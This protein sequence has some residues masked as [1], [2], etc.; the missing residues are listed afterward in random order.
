MLIG[1]GHQVYVPTLP[2]GGVLRLKRGEKSLHA[3]E[4]EQYAAGVITDL[5]T[6]PH[7]VDG[8]QDSP[9]DVVA[10]P[11][12]FDIGVHADLAERNSRLVERMAHELARLRG[13]DSVLR[14]APDALRV[15][16]PDWHAD[17]LE[18]WLNAWMKTNGP[19]IR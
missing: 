4:L 5:R 11:E 2:L 7:A 1:N 6:S 3:T 16:A 15:H 10:E 19:F 17:E 13:I 14:S 9:V 8:P 18:Q 12:S